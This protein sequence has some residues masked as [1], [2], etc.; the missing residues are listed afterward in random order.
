MMIDGAMKHRDGEFSFILKGRRNKISYSF[1]TKTQE[2]KLAP[3]GYWKIKADPYDLVEASFVDERGYKRLWKGP[4]PKGIQVKPRS[5]ASMGTWYLV[6]LKGDNQFNI[7]LKP[8]HLLLPIDRWK[9]SV[10]SVTDG[11]TGEVF[12]LYKGES[13]Q[14]GQG[15][16]RVLRGSRS[17][18]ML[19][20]LDLFR[21]NTYATEMSRILQTNDADIRSCYTDLLEKDENAK[22]T[23][24][25]VF[26]YSGITQG[27]KSLKIKQTS[28]NDP[29]FM[30]CMYYKLRALSFSL[31]Q[32]LVGELS[33]QF[34]TVQ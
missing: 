16:R 18:Q 15:I 24:T 32:S 25:Y 34:N 9:G 31:T 28:L 6:Y 33:F 20:K 17:I 4:Y 5:I 14:N 1:S 30:E 13:A 3:N 21:F 22:G 29:S 19:Y 12:S 11:I 7:L 8:I 26:A 27:I 2:P 23:L 10:L